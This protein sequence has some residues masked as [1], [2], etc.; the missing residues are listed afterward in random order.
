[1]LAAFGRA[2]EAGSPLSLVTFGSGE[3]NPSAAVA[4]RVI[5]LGFLPDAER[6]NA[7]AAAEA[8][9]QSSRYEAFSRTVMEAWLAGT[10][11]IA[12]GGSEVVRWHCERSGAG[13]VYDDEAEFTECLRFVA[14]A[15]DLAR[16]LAE[17]GRDYVLE[18]Y[19]WDQVLDGV[20]EGLATWT[21][22]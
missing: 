4:A 20:E 13:L 21:T 10:P 1:M 16:K 15:P 5:D 14:E 17:G 9:I 2:V 12:N 22:P 11:V 18:H 8:Y 7:F 3:V 19:T 6:D